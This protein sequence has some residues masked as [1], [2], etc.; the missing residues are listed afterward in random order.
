MP[1]DAYEALKAQRKVQGKTVTD[2]GSYAMAPSEHIL[3]FEPGSSGTAPNVVV[4]NACECPVGIPYV[5]RAQGANLA[6][7]NVTVNFSGADV[8]NPTDI[9][10]TAAGDY[11]IFMSVGDQWVVL[12]EVST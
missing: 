8:V 7:K 4:P 2:M 10:L 3:Y 9:V 1:N 12:Q 11:A 6:A 5:I